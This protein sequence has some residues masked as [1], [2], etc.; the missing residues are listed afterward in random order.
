MANAITTAEVAAILGVSERRVRE[1]ADLGR[2]RVMIRT[3][4]GRLYDQ[5]DVER[6]ARE[7]EAGR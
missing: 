6:L 7:R 2:V 1:L 3:P 5:H 4:L